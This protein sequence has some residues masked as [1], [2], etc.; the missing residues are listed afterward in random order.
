[1]SSAFIQAQEQ[2]KIQIE[3]SGFLNFDEENYPGAKVLTRDDSSQI[4]IIHDGVNMWCDQ[5]IHYSDDNFIE[6]YG[7][8]KMKQ[9]DTI[10]MNAKYVEYS[11]KTQLAFASGDV[12]LTDPNSTITTDTLYMDRVKQQSYYKSGGTVVRDSSG[13]ITSRIGRYYMNTKKYEFITN[14]K[15]VNPDYVI[16]SNRLDFYSETGHAYLYGPSTIT[17]EESITYC[18]KGFYNTETKIGYAIKN[19]RIDYDKLRQTATCHMH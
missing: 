9:G 10:N 1:M 5:A 14:V 3:Y 16:E 4:H 12:I 6:A 19:S 7:N 17:T 8:V 13:T 18:E 2:R 15:L 11:G